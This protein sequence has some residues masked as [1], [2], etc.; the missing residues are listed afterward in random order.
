MA[1]IFR[2]LEQS[3]ERLK[4]IAQTSDDLIFQLDPDGTVIFCS[5]AVLQYGYEV[6]DVVGRNFLSFLAEENQETAQ[7]AFRQALDGAHIQGLELS[8]LTAK[9]VPYCAEI[10]VAPIR[11][12]NAVI[13]LQGISRD[14]SK[15]K[16]DETKLRN[17]TFELQTANTALVASRTAALNLMQDAVEAHAHAKRTNEELLREMAEHQKAQDQLKS[18]VAEKEVMLR[19]IHHRV[20]NNLQVI[21][22]LVSL[23]ADG[24]EDEGLRAVIGDIRDRIRTM[25][26][27]HEKLYQTGDL[28]QLNFAEYAASLLQFLWRSHGA[29]AEQ[30]RYTIEVAPVNM[31][32]VTAVP[33]GLI[34]NELVNNTLK[35]AFPD[36][37]SGEVRV[38]LEYDAAS[39]MV[40]LRVHDNGVGLPAEFDWRSI[41]S[42]GL[43]LV[44]LLVDQLQGTVGLK[45]GS[46]TEFVI[47]FPYGAGNHA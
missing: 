21:S 17:F 11:F 29:L 6:T 27:V 16:E 4:T 39:E 5:P 1:V 43:R 38:S 24:L 7:T 14:I 18:T 44:Q 31:P 12:R 2:N 25:A 46:G 3:E 15:R 8:L 28:A 20:K 33:C 42:L 40:C 32:I 45:T 23:Q 41:Q 19:E 36:G 22:S 30:V 9:G 13:G 35:H 47:S 37:R 26:L 34:L 10:N